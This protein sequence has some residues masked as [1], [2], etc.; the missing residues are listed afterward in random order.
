MGI[1]HAAGVA[2][3]ARDFVH[4]IAVCKGQSGAGARCQDRVAGGR[5]CVS[6]WSPLPGRA[7][8]LACEQAS[9]HTMALGFSPVPLG[10][11]THDGSGLYFSAVPPKVAAGGRTREETGP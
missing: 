6:H 5:L 2:V 1:G 10:T 11:T 7:R 4:F 9:T 3:P 8:V